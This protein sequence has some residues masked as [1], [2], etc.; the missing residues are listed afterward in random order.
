MGLSKSQSFLAFAWLG[1]VF[2]E[3][4]NVK[5]FHYFTSNSLRSLQAFSFWIFSVSTPVPHVGKNF[6][7][8][9]FG[10]IFE[11]LSINFRVNT[12]H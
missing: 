6:L 7:L 5:D 4:S 11:Q 10:L 12:L 3:S 1:L 2:L 9:G 8:Q